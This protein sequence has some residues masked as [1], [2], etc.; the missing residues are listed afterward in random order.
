MTGSGF[1]FRKKRHRIAIGGFLLMVGVGLLA[2]CSSGTENGALQLVVADQTV[3][4]PIRDVIEVTINGD[5]P[6]YPDSAAGG[7]PSVAGS[8]TAGEPLSLILWK[9]ANEEAEITWPI[10]VPTEYDS[11]MLTVVVE[12]EDNQV[13][14]SSSALN[15]RDAFDRV[16]P[17]EEERQQQALAAEEQAQAAE[18]EALAAEEEAQALVSRVRNEAAQLNTQMTDMDRQLQ[19]VLDEHEKVY[20]DDGWADFDEIAAKYR[21]YTRTSPTPTTASVTAL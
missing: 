17:A 12:I 16:N 21:D 6:V 1:E 19:D 11:D 18:E 4:N 8:W 13:A 9:N 5:D 2:A 7:S 14:V 10:D 3:E 15:I 20:G